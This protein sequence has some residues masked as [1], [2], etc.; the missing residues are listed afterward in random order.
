MFGRVN[1]NTGRS[2]SVDGRRK[3]KRSSLSRSV[4]AA[5]RREGTWW[6]VDGGTKGKNE[7]IEEVEW[8]VKWKVEKVL[9]LGRDRAFRQQ[10]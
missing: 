6:V 7:G 5:E 3:Q 10:G 2:D 9:G 8:K 1:G 4:S